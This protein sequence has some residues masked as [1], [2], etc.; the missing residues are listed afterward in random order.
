MVKLLGQTKSQWM[1]PRGGHSSNVELCEAAAREH[2][3]E[4]FATSF[5]D[6]SP[7]CL[8]GFAPAPVEGNAL[9]KALKAYPKGKS[10]GIDGW[11][12]IELA[13]LP[14]CAIDSLAALLTCCQNWL[15]WPTSFHANLMSLLPKP[16]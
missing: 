15:V 11:A 2:Q 12:P 6:V 13:S 3:L 7:K 8:E 5:A 4:Y 16:Q 10:L 14:L 1:P 9:Q